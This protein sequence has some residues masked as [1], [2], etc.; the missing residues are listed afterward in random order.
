MDK[1]WRNSADSAELERV[2]E[3]SEPIRGQLTWNWR[4]ASERG[5]ARE[6]CIV[7]GAV[8]AFRACGSMSLGDQPRLPHSSAPSATAP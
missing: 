4:A 1:T 2:K 3:A 8:V 6:G 5:A 7:V